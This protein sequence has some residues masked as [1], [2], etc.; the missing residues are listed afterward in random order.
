ME[1]PISNKVRTQVR[2]MH[3]ER[4]LKRLVRQQLELVE[5]GL[6]QADGGQEREVQSGRIDITARD[7]FG[8]F[9]VIDSRP[10]PALRARWSRCSPTPAIW[11]RKR[12][13]RVARC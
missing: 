10:G 6:V 9:V 4:E 13:C 3:Y 11:R 2:I 1:Q 8:H 7:R 5:P 12:G